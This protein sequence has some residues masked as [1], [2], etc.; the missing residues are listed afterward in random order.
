MN[1]RA[2]SCRLIT[3]GLLTVGILA[4]SKNDDST[5][6]SPTT[7]T[8]TSTSQDEKLLSDFII[9]V[10]ACL[11]LITQGL[12]ASVMGWQTST[13]NDG[14][15]PDLAYSCSSQTPVDD[16]SQINENG[17]LANY[18]EGFVSGSEDRVSGITV[19]ESLHFGNSNNP[20]IQAR[21]QKITANIYQRVMSSPLPHK[22][23][24]AIAHK[25]NLNIKVN[26][27]PIKVQYQ[28]WGSGH[29]YEVDFII[30]KDVNA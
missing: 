9:P 21:F 4:C 30:G 18:I 15:P 27:I 3:I 20:D 6:K 8:S 23:A 29:G 17:K 2:V 28:K 26:G 24:N 12:T 22:I 1:T 14:S 19:N 7:S 5:W 25:K 13:E 16:D 11:L 10:D